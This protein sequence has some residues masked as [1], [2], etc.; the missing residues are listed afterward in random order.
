MLLLPYSCSSSMLLL[1]LLA[2]LLPCSSFSMLLLFPALLC[3]CRRSVDQRISCLLAC[4]AVVCVALLLQIQLVEEMVREESR[5]L[6]AKIV[7]EATA[8]V[9]VT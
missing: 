6:N 7:H 1:F 8:R 3:P 2:P 9:Q 4:L 5:D